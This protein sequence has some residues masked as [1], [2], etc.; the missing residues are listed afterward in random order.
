[1]ISSLGYMVLMLYFG[2]KGLFS[3]FS[4]ESK[5]ICWMK[6]TMNLVTISILFVIGQ[7]NHVLLIEIHDI[8]A[9]I[10]QEKIFFSTLSHVIK[11]YPS[12]ET[13][14][15]SGK[16]LNSFC[17][18]AAQ[19]CSP[20]WTGKKRFSFDIFHRIKVHPSHEANLDSRNNLHFFMIWHYNHV[21]LIA[22]HVIGGLVW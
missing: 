12:N 19:S 9:L 21:L 3:P 22:T 15:D 16:N 7:C 18:W 8:C 10:L 20:H 2:K 11:V 6:Q 14:L 13:N 4:L 5:Y 17:D 1:M